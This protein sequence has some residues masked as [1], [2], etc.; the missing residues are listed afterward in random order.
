VK[1]KQYTAI[2]YKND[3]EV[4]FYLDQSGDV[5]FSKHRENVEGTKI[6]QRIIGGF[7][8]NYLV[9]CIIDEGFI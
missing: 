6:P 1:Y 2:A 5:T 9:E 8:D 4:G 3:T 7:S